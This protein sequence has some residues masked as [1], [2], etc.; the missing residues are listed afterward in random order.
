MKRPI[1]DEA[2]RFI[3]H[4][5]YN[6]EYYRKLLFKLSILK[7]KQCISKLFRPFLNSID[8]ALSFSKKPKPYTERYVYPK[9]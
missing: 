1:L 2:D 7:V 5:E 4:R 6:C 8:N 3:L 9:K